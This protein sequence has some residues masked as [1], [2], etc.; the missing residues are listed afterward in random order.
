MTEVEALEALLVQQTAIKDAGGIRGLG[1]LLGRLHTLPLPPAPAS[2]PGGAWHH[3]AEGSPT[4]ELSAAAEWLDAAEAEAP[5][6]E[7]AHFGEQRTPW[8]PPIPARACRPQ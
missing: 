8:R 1:E 6:R 2:R 4:D 7:L 3:I 5:A